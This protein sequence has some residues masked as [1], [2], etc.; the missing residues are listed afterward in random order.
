MQEKGALKEAFINQQVTFDSQVDF[1]YDQICKINTLQNITTPPLPFGDQPSPSEPDP[2]CITPRPMNASQ[3]ENLKNNLDRT[4]NDNQ[5]RGIYRAIMSLDE[6]DEIQ[7]DK[8]DLARLNSRQQ[9][10][11][12]FVYREN[13]PLK[14][15]DIITEAEYKIIKSA[16]K[17]RTLS[18]IE[19]VEP[20]VDRL[21]L[22]PEVMKKA[23]DEAIDALHS[24][25]AVEI[26]TTEDLNSEEAS[27]SAL[28]DNEEQSENDDAYFSESELFGDSGSD[29]E[30]GNESD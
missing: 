20:P 4:T 27:S 7:N 22:C 9:W 28:H 6:P 5:F 23:E 2:R 14:L 21:P 16:Q 13:N 29:F 18:S 12:H 15:F 1:L 17:A 11:L 24:K 19:Q 8:L 30:S 26:A 25:F 10:L 3:L